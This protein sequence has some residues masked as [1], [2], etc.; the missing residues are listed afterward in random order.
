MPVVQYPYMVVTGRPSPLIPL[1][2]VMYSSVQ[3]AVRWD[4]RACPGDGASR[5]GHARARGIQAVRPVLEFG[6]RRDDVS[7]VHPCTWQS[8]QH[9]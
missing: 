8:M 3:Q 1:E 6:V 7:S 9:T 5:R 4:A 2:R